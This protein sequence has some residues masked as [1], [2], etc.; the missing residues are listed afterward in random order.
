MERKKQR[1]CSV[2][3]PLAVIEFA[4]LFCFRT[5]RVHFCYCAHLGTFHDLHTIWLHFCKSTDV[6][7]RA[8][9]RARS[10]VCVWLFVYV[11]VRACV[12]GWGGGGGG[13]W[14]MSCKTHLRDSAVILHH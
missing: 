10:R 1:V 4:W 7:M 3:L 5:S 14:C 11:C 12:W 6:C 9:V 2:P 13:W 8:C